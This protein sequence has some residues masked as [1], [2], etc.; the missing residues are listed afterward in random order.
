MTSKASPVS[1]ANDIRPLFRPIDIAH[2]LPF[3]VRLDDYEYM[4]DAAGD[5]RNARL[6]GECLSGTRQPR[7]PIGGPFWTPEQLALY[8]RWM[9]GGFRP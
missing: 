3:D 6:V 8:E 2:M 7:M 4:S 5:H 9:S 1:F